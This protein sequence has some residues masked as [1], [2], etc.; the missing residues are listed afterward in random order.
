MIVSVIDPDCVGLSVNVAGAKAHAAPA[1]SP[2]QLK[3]T[4]AFSAALAVTLSL[5][6]PLPPGLMLTLVLPRA[7]LKSG[8]AAAT[9]TAT[10]CDLLGW[11]SESP[12]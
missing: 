11:N 8:A 9:V 4:V 3:L 6:D 2:E 12:E 1:G 10:G 7:T 5:A